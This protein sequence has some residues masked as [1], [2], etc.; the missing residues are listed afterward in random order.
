MLPR[1]QNIKGPLNWLSV[2]TDLLMLGLT[3]FDLAWLMFDA[4]YSTQMVKD[5]ID[6]ILPFYNSIHEDFYFYDGIIV[7]IFILEFVIRWLVSIQQKIYA[8]WFFYPFVHWY[9]VLGCFPTSSFR[10]LRLFRIIGLTYRLHHWK[11][12]D[13]NNYAL[14]NTLGY[15][16][17]IAI[18]EISDRVV[19]KVLSEAKNEI[20]RGQPLNEAILKD[21]VQ[22]RQAVLA[23]LISKSLQEG[24]QAKY[25]EYQKLLKKYVIKTVENTVIN[26]PEV[27]QIKRIP[28]VGAP[29]Q[30][31]LNT[32]TSQIVF[33]VVDQL[34]SDLSA[35]E[36][37]AMVTLVA[38]SI[39]E[40]FLQQQ[41]S[42]SAELTNE[43]IVESIDLIV[44]RVQVKQWK[45]L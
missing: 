5:L 45:S 6:P 15:Y 36:N 21:V 24:I 43:I 16:Y 37:Q 14:F 3:I 27:Q 29:M 10:I 4:L 35:T 41:S 13:L 28:V 7:S 39:L 42:K 33:G 17:N 9:D 8:K 31:A 1:F 18:E 2:I 34:I 23:K 20:N 19:I 22:P 12:V 30:K 40:V 32:A 38:E 11:V 25:P 44:K 26:N